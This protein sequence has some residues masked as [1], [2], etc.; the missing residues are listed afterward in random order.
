MVSDRV[1]RAIDDA[2]HRDHVIVVAAAGQTYLDNILSWLSPEDS[3][4]EPARFQDVV[5]VAGCS[6]DGSPWA[7]SHR[8]PNV[9]IT[10]PGDAVWVA[11]FDPARVDADGTCVPVVRAASGTSYSAAIVAGAAAVWLAHWGGRRRLT[12]RYPGVPLAWVFREA[13]QRSA[14]PHPDAS[15]DAVDFGPGVLDVHRLLTTPLPPPDTV[16]EPP[17]TVGNLLTT[18]ETHLDAAAEVL[19]GIRDAGLRAGAAVVVLAGLAAT[20][21][22]D[23]TDHLAAGYAA[24]EVGEGP[25]RPDAR[26]VLT[27]AEHL[28]RDATEA[29]DDLADLA[30]EQGQA[31]VDAL[32][33]A[34]GRVAAVSADAVETVRGWFGG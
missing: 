10:A 18:V 22:D 20:A 31:V 16:P 4:V 2:V 12:Q 5:A 9:D 26:D 28:L 32:V 23:L 15:W 21:L 29:A 27:R 17:A 7:E 8:G 6:T 14:T 30:A 33:A 25:G 13:L 1:S 11:G 19:S 3:V 24:M 34:A